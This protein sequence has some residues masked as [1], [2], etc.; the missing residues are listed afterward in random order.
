MAV[1]WKDSS[2]AQALIWLHNSH[3]REDIESRGRELIRV[4]LHISEAGY[5]ALLDSDRYQTIYEKISRIRVR[6]D[7]IGA[8]SRA[9]IYDTLA[10]LKGY[11]IEN[12]WDEYD[13]C[14]SMARARLYPTWDTRDQE[15]F[16]AREELLRFRDFFISYTNRNA[17]AVNLI[18]KRV[19]LP[20]DRAS[21][22]KSPSLN[23]V[24]KL[25]DTVLRTNNLRGFYDTSVI[26]IGDDIKSTVSDGAERSLVLVQIITG[27]SLTTPEDG[28]INWCHR[29]FTYYRAGNPQF[30]AVARDR[31]RKIA[32]LIAVKC[33][34]EDNPVT[35]ITP[36]YLPE[37]YREWHTVMEKIRGERLIA[38]DHDS[39]TQQI[40]TL[41]KTIV[42][43][44]QELLNGIVRQ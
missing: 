32:F 4:R 9:P 24:A 44:R 42:A 30:R 10:A 17:G 36:A 7:D 11:R 8:K 19:F 14:R 37:S 38:K 12:E 40:G 35:C 26:G 2:E 23:F 33:S 27:A 1:S 20:S 16:D 25:V 3:S 34:E 6:I 41:A 43:F 18:Y 28:N 22:R 15:N 5:E 21:A 29:E 31:S 39:I 13:I